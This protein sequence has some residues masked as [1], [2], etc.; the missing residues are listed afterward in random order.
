MLN[1]L[2]DLPRDIRDTIVKPICN[3]DHYEVLIRLRSN[4]VRITLNDG[5]PNSTS[6]E[7]FLARP[8]V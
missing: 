7:P 8:K 2:P 5:N 1:R 3:A 4:Y 6:A